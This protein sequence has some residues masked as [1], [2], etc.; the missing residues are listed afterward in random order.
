MRTA[1]FLMALAVCG[2]AAD[3]KTDW[4]ELG[5]RDGR[6]GAPPQAETYAARCNI[7]AD[8]ARYEEGYRAGFD[9]RPRVP[10]P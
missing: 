1:A 4:Y 10:Y 6:L 7:K 5:A 8:P 2:C 3:C 9:M